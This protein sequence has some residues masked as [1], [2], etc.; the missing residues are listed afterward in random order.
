MRI[1]ASDVSLARTP[2]AGSTILNVLPACI[3]AAEPQDGVQIMVAVAL[4]AEG[5]GARL[6]A[7]VTRKSWDTLGLASGQAVFAQIKGVAL[8]DFS[9]ASRPG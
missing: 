7:R 1:A 6:L 8:V 9:P 4:G 3:L 5:R 2:S